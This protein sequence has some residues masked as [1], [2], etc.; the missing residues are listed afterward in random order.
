MFWDVPEC[1]MFRVLS[2][3]FNDMTTSTFNIKRIPPLQVVIAPDLITL[4][5]VGFSWKTNR[6]LTGSYHYHKKAKCLVSRH[7]RKSILYSKKKILLELRYQFFWN[8]ISSWSRW[9]IYRKREKRIPQLHSSLPQTSFFI[10]SQCDEGSSN[11]CLLKNIYRYFGD[12]LW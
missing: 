2:T 3:P 10:P 5:A 12:I 1:S 9:P 6:L 8:K 4:W 7:F 11:S